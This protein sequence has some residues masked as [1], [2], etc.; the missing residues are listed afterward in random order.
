VLFSEKPPADPKSAA[1]VLMRTNRR[2]HVS[3]VLASLHWLPVKF[4]IEFRILI[5][6]YKA[7]N[8]RAPSYL[9]GEVHA[10]NKV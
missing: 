9:K 10:R 6:T 5:L 4:R 1:R 7:V 3:P 2:D 8:D